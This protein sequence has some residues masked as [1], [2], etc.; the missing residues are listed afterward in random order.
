MGDRNTEYRE[1]IFYFIIFYAVI[2]MSSFDVIICMF[3]FFYVIIF[4]VNIFDDIVFCFHFF[5][6]IIYVFFFVVIYFIISLFFSE[7][8]THFSFFLAATTLWQHSWN[9]RNA[10]ETGLL[11]LTT[12]S[13]LP[14][15]SWLNFST[16]GINPN[17]GS[18]GRI[19]LPKIEQI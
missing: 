1:C 19:W 15:A 11:F 5:H 2:F 18:R 4:N 8:V 3:P 17:P 7:K 12:T 10:R 13:R 16:R 6:V 14:M 9:F